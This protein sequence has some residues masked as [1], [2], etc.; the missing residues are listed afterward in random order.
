MV[1][2]D[3]LYFF[4]PFY[5]DSSGNEVFPDLARVKLDGTGLEMIRLSVDS[6]IGSSFNIAGEWAFFD[7]AV[8][9]LSD[10]GI[11]RIYKPSSG[12]SA[13]KVEEVDRFWSDWE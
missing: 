3:Y 2:G 7:V 12:I 5:Y 9:H 6:E 4:P 11:D 13:A 8:A 1:Y 10:S